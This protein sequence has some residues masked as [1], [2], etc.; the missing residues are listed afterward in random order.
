MTPAVEHEPGS[1]DPAEIP[2]E[3]HITE[4]DGQ[5]SFLD[6]VRTLVHGEKIS[7]QRTD[8]D[9][10]EPS[11]DAPADSATVEDL[12]GGAQ[13]EDA[14]SAEEP[15]AP[16]EV[17]DDWLPGRWV[18]ESVVGAP[19][20]GRR[21]RAEPVSE[22]SPKS[23]KSTR[24]R[25]SG[26]TVEQAARRGAPGAEVQMSR[27]QHAPELEPVDA[28]EPERERTELAP[29]PEPSLSGRARR[30]EAR[31]ESRSAR[32]EAKA[33]DK[34]ERAAAAREL[35]LERKDAKATGRSE[36]TAAA[37]ELKR[38]RKASRAAA[39]AERA[40]TKVR[41]AEKRRAAKE[42]AVLDRAAAL[43]AKAE[44]RSARDAAK[45]RPGAERPSP[46]AGT[47]A[48]SQPAN[49]DTPAPQ[50]AVDR[51]RP[52]AETE[53]PETGQEKAQE[54]VERSAA[55]ATARTDREAARARAAREREAAL[56]HA[57]IERDA[58]TAA[59]VATKAEQQ[60]ARTRAKAQRR[61]DAG[62]VKAERKAAKAARARDAAERAAAAEQARVSR[63][64][65]ESLAA[66][67]LAKARSEKDAERAAAKA[68]AAIARVTARA[69]RRVEGVT[70]KAR[71]KA[72]RAATKAQRTLERTAGK[73]QAHVDRANARALALAQRAAARA[74]IATEID[75]QVVAWDSAADP[76]PPQEGLADYIARVE[77]RNLTSS[78]TRGRLSTPVKV[79]LVTVVVAACAA[80]PWA[81][82][83]VPRLFADLVP[84][85]HAA[86][87]PV[88]DPPVDPPTSSVVP[89]EVVQQAQGLSGVRLRAAGPPREV[90]VP[91]L[92]VDSSV[93]AISG[94]SGSLLPPS[95]PQQ[96]GW[97]REGQPAGAQYGSA[98]VTGH[99]V[100]TGGGA[101]DH[102]D[103]LVVGDSVRVRT[104]AGWIRYV[105]QRTQI[106]STEQ[107]AR[108][109]KEVFTLGGPGRLV[110]ITCD[111]WNGVTYESNAVVFA[112]P[113]AD[114]PSDGAG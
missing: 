12:I 25:R 71:T 75:A 36:R 35:E 77:S 67:A 86:G 33:R 20:Q 104:D 3:S 84:G 108:D 49:A 2:A 17:L 31:A 59:K 99:T 64:A 74:G 29:P 78:G 48:G 65:E 72:D 106:Y 23:A 14:A 26:R 93:I 66:V 38:E 37:D 98:V 79:T 9:S 107:L 111:D 85:G 92:H 11:S 83:S 40:A 112:A 53:V 46:T 4:P 28:G 42:Q 109:A 1:S 91:R 45:A 105:V 34:S 24:G 61:I 88:Q 21:R 19:R 32:S 113:V 13:A 54:R 70:T 7:A 101:L 55:E 96:L 110:L 114:E 100:H 82:P 22:K 58:A 41:A 39:G 63:L 43:A 73:A 81:A 8:S 51:P 76:V 15:A 52:S 6:A 69:Q 16:V 44:A 80:L 57:R 97:W 90:S 10:W 18:A 102:L 62:R 103:K 5:A 56:E 94:Q 95:D 47:A 27:R 68:D 60:A 30:R 89:P 50:P 87:T